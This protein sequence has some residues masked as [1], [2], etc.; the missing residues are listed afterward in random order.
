MTNRLTRIALFIPIL[1]LAMLGLANAQTITFPAGTVA[2]SNITI[3]SWTAVNS[4]YVQQM[5]TLNIS[6]Y[7]GSPSYL[8]YN[9][10]TANFEYTY[11][12][13]TVVPS[14]IESNSSG[15]LTTWSNITNTTTQVELDFFNAT[16][17]TLSNTGT[18]GIGEA[19]QLSSTYAQ[20]DDGASVFSNYW[21]FA[22]LPSG[23]VGS[24][25]TVNN[26]ISIPYS[27][28]ANNGGSYL[29]PNNILD[30]YG[31]IPLA[32]SAYNACGGYI[33][34][35]SVLAVP[36]VCWD[37]NTGLVSNGD[38]LGV[39]S[40]TTS[41]ANTAGLTTGTNIYSIAWLSSTNALFSYNYGATS[42]LTTDIPTTAIPI[43]FANT[44]GSQATLTITWLRTRA[45]P[46]SG[47]MPSAT[48]GAITS[49]PPTLTLSSST[50]NYAQNDTITAVAFNSTDTVSI[51]INGYNASSAVNTT[52][53]YLNT[54]SI[55]F[56]GNLS[57]GSNNITAEE[58]NGGSVASILTITQ[59]T[60]NLTIS[61]PAS[62]TYNN[63]NLSISASSQANST[64]NLTGLLI[65]NQLNQNLL[66]NG[67]SVNSSTASIS[68]VSYI[69][70]L[71]YTQSGTNLSAGTY[72]YNY[73]VA[74]NTNYTSANIYGNFTI[75]QATPSQPTLLINGTATSTTTYGGVSI[76]INAT[77]TTSS[78]INS[79]CLW[80]INY[81]YSSNGTQV[82]FN[83]TNIDNSNPF[84]L[85]YAGNL[86]WNMSFAGN[87][88]YT[89]QVSANNATLTLLSAFTELNY[90]FTN[91]T[92]LLY[93]N[94]PSFNI[95][96][97]DQANDTITI[98]ASL[99][100]YAGDEVFHDT[101][102]INDTNTTINQ[103]NSTLTLASLGAGTYTIYFNASDGIGAYITNST[104]FTISQ[105]TPTLNLTMPS[106]YV[107]N[108]INQT[109][110]T[111]TNVSYAQ[112]NSDL[113]S[114]LYL[115]GT[116][117]GTSAQ[118]SNLTGFS[119]VQTGTNLG[120]NT[121]TYVW[122]TT[123]NAN[124]TSATINGSFSISQASPIL[125]L[126][127]PS[128]FT[129]NGS[130]GTIGFGV[131]DI[132][133]Q[134]LANL[135]LNYSA[136]TLPAF[137]FDSV[138]ANTTSNSTYNTS[139]AGIYNTTLYSLATQNY[140]A[141]TTNAFW[142]IT[143]ATGSVNLLLN[144]SA[145]NYTIYQHQTIPI[146]ASSTNNNNVQLFENGT[147]LSAQYNTTDAFTSST[148][149][150]NNTAIMNFTA[151]AYSQNYT[152]ATQTYFLNISAPSFAYILSPSYKYLLANGT[153]NG[154]GTSIFNLLNYSYTLNG[155]SYWGIQNITISFNNSTNSNQAISEG[156]NTAFSNSPIYNEFLNN[157]QNTYYL[158][159]NAT[160][161]YNDTNT[162]IIPINSTTYV[163]PTITLPLASRFF[164]LYNYTYNTISTL[165]IANQSAGSFGISYIN[166]SY[167]VPNS[168]FT[169]SVPP[170]PQLASSFSYSPSFS[171]TV[172]V[173][174][175]AV[176]TNGYSTSAINNITVYNYTPPTTTLLTSQAYIHNQSYLFTIGSGTFP[177]S[178]IEI[179][180]GDGTETTVLSSN[181]I[182]NEAILYHDYTIA[183]QYVID[184][185]A[186]DTYGQMTNQTLTN[187]DLTVNS[188][189]EPSVLSVLPNEP[190]N[191][192]NNNTETYYFTVAEGSYPIQNITIYWNDGYA[193][194][195][196]TA[197]FFNITGSFGVI[198]TFP[199][200]NAYTITT[201]ICDQLQDC[202]SQNFP[203][204]MGFALQNATVAQNYAN[205]TEYEQYLQALQRN[206]NTQALGNPNTVIIPIIIIASVVAVSVLGI[207]Q[208]NRKRRKRNIFNS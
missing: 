64:G 28:Y 199:F 183:Q 178:Y 30:F 13:G 139:N 179:Y 138:V 200:M 161:I 36:A 171:G 177:V 74:G 72:S 116:L 3:G 126:T 109:I 102:Y 164:V 17:N 127:M 14:W 151:Q 6:D 62:F 99:V 174:Y 165:F 81:Y 194:V 144:G 82:L 18:T 156:N 69:E 192:A 23:W 122:N 167:G 182:N 184:V 201:Y 157:S 118:T 41:T 170:S 162:T 147:L 8:T 148:I 15:N 149:N 132:N 103:S 29:N 37:I 186:V 101:S 40:T 130:N 78:C 134:V 75:S 19:P 205:M 124:Y 35:S 180:W 100:N 70:N 120:V 125:N 20:Y 21:N 86:T 88:N 52:T 141:N 39:T 115:N 63:T 56:N 12:N 114:N 27:S 190:Y 107:Y 46:P 136:Y 57:V 2:Y 128:N 188:F 59:A 189:V 208:Y 66:L 155:S 87:T 105:A 38:T 58:S 129:Y 195:S 32:T 76:P 106:S 67:T 173:N 169:Q 117:V 34:S 51:F 95:T 160:D 191:G 5:I 202:V 121:Y 193:N 43:G 84:V 145:S 187:P 98:N 140:T 89:S 50:I 154:T 61:V 26:G 42:Q 65:L 83:Q 163:F 90:Y 54:T 47:A 146:N 53:I 203:I 206:P 119:Y 45:Y 175:T 152:N 104:T 24:G 94:P 198:H 207:M 55:W 9:G 25:Y 4:A 7:S 166:T 93:P 181:F 150:P 33:G 22:G 91:S 108:N 80:N 133:N 73:T 11:E 49:P 79:Q 168:N 77:N 48:F 142:N 185:K 176:D 85:L 110:S 60:P 92:P 111:Y 137:D 44:Q 113:T 159:I 68:N 123:G 153:L 71:T 112:N 197:N 204:V 158:T 16:T 10:S 131:N 96:A 143:Q 172:V 1:M 135:E 97:I 31:D 196:P